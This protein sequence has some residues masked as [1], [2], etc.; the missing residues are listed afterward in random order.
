VLVAL[1]ISTLVEFFAVAGLLFHLLL[2]LTKTTSTMNQL[3]NSYR[4]NKDMLRMTALPRRTTTTTT[5]LPGEISFFA[6][7]VPW[8]SLPP[9]PKPAQLEGDEID[10]STWNNPWPRVRRTR[11][12]T[13]TANVSTT[14][15]LGRRGRTMPRPKKVLVITDKDGNVIDLPPPPPSGRRPMAMAQTTSLQ[16][17]LAVEAVDRRPIT[18]TRTRRGRR[19]PRVP[20]NPLVRRI[21][22]APRGRG[23]AMPPKEKSFW[24]KAKSFWPKAIL[25]RPTATVVV[26]PSPLPS[27]PTEDNKNYTIVPKAVPKTLE[28]N[29]TPLQHP[30]LEAAIWK[31]ATSPRFIFCSEQASWSGSLSTLSDETESSSDSSS[32]VAHMQTLPAVVVAVLHDLWPDECSSSS[33]LTEERT[34]ASSPQSDA[35]PR[36]FTSYHEWYMSDYSP[37]TTGFEDYIW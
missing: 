3:S 31:E 7:P 32:A 29:K 21:K 25:Q 20:E 24:P 18:T 34:V 16:R 19:V 1:L 23:M 22:P 36:R 2:P 11:C 14:A 35:T 5:P 17:A 10:S 6:S 15:S 12:Q 37:V 27:A 8:G 13:T 4:N 30:H 9:P 28:E 26:V 33:L